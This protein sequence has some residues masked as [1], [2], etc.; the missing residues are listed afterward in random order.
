MARDRLRFRPKMT[1]ATLPGHNISTGA[2]QFLSDFAGVMGNLNIKLN[3][4]ADKRAAKKAVAAGLIAGRDPMFRTLKGDGLAVEAFNNSA[5]D[6]FASRLEQRSRQEIGKLFDKHNS[7]PKQLETV[8]SEYRNGVANEIPAELLE[9]FDAF[10]NKNTRPL[11]DKARD[12]LLR[13]NRNQQA[14]A[15]SEVIIE[16]LRGAEQM[17]FNS[18]DDVLFEENITGERNDFFAKLVANGPPQAFKIGNQEFPTDDTR[19]GIVDPA[20]I[21][22]QMEQFDRTVIIGRV[23]GKFDRSRKAGEGAEFARDFIDHPIDGFTTAERSKISASMT[24]SLRADEAINKR[25]NDEA[26]AAEEIQRSRRVGDLKRRCA[27]GQCTEEDIEQAFPQ[28]ISGDERGRLLIQLD[29]LRSKQ[30]DSIAAQQRVAFAIQAGIPLDAK[31]P[32][33]RKAVHAYFKQRF[34]D[35]PPTAETMTEIVDFI[36]DVA[37]IPTVVRGGIRSLARSANPEQAV[38]AADMIAR[39]QKAAPQVLETMPK[40]EKA[41]SLLVSNNVGAGVEPQ[42]AVELARLRVYETPASEMEQLRKVFMEKGF[43]KDN[44]G[45]LADLIDDEFDPIFRTQPSTPPAMMG[46]FNDLVEQYYIRTR[47]EELARK[48]AGQDLVRVWG[49]SDVVG[50][51]VEAQE[52]RLQMVKYPPEKVH[53]DGELNKWMRPQL[54]ADISDQKISGVKAENVFLVADDRTAREKTRTWQVWHVRSDGRPVPVLDVDNR[55][56]R[57][58]PQFDISPAGKSAADSKKKA[59]ARAQ[60]I[61]LERLEILKD[62]T[63][64]EQLFGL[65]AAQRTR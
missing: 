48:L 37:V 25:V 64:A 29:D 36:R 30:A 14:G 56:A 21:I 39:I 17:A 42:Q 50:S 63:V 51:R 22:Q 4:R 2:P 9:P 5:L 65:P 32:D 54:E 10:W 38:L 31:N 15:L 6:T 12:E 43:E 20:K 18:I 52:G 40:D 28:D 60:S 53:G 49:V 27:A 19:S 45:S 46:E 24:S 11:I 44:S 58:R 26:K 47:D 41:F 34:G 13:I 55:P 8:F 59:K 35:A 33:D 57:W 16:R 61:H 7:D 23:L 3:E 1:V 62:G